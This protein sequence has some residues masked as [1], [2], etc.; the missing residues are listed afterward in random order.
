M[1][2]VAKWRP[3]ERAELFQETASRRGVLPAIVEKDFWVCWTLRRLFLH[4]ERRPAML[5]KGGTSLSKVYNVIERFSED[6]D[7]SL[8]RHDL[9]FSG[10]LDPEQRP[11]QKGEEQAAR[12]IEA[13]VHS[14]PRGAAPGRSCC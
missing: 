6:I 2:Q 10:D 11:V 8:D 13:G 14:I 9:G 5:F 12:P 7:L 4:P 1:D 3:E